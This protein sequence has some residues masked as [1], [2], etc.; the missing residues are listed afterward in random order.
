MEPHVLF[1]DLVERLNSPLSARAT[2]HRKS[3]A[4]S[5]FP[6]RSLQIHVPNRPEFMAHNR[7]I[8]TTHRPPEFCYPSFIAQGGLV[9][10]LS[11]CRA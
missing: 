11:T 9:A 10:R 2:N 8:Y 1:A 6:F 7:V 5:V 3:F 4:V